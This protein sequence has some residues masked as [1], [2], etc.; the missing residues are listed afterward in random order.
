MNRVF[1][2]SLLILAGTLSSGC[3]SCSNPYDY[4][5]PVANCGCD[6]CNTACGGRA[7]SVLSGQASHY[8]AHEA[9]GETI[10]TQ[11]PT[12]AQPMVG[13]HVAP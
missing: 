12:L 8:A 1:F 10:I 2:A 13:E 3:R 4:S 6:S 5:S 7:G 9:L 11:E